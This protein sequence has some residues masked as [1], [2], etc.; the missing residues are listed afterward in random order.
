MWAE[1]AYYE[2]QGEALYTPEEMQDELRRIQEEREEHDAWEDMV[3][4]WIGLRKAM[5]KQEAPLH[6]IAL[7]AL[8]IERA[9]LSMNEQ[10]RL[11]NVMRRC[12]WERVKS[13]GNFLW[14][15]GTVEESP[16]A[17]GTL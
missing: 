8:H 9:R 5:T 2:A 17:G 4:E 15:P 13:H 1:A 14:Q 7:E 16:R 12:G 11:A 10:K 3:Q 6:Q